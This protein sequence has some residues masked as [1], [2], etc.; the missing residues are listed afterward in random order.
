MWSYVLA[1]EWHIP[2]RQ[3][4]NNFNKT[5]ELSELYNTTL[6]HA[7]I[8]EIYPGLPDDPTVIF[9]F[10]ASEQPQQQGH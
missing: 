6:F 10:L 7:F 1:K 8:E 3:Y 2:G 9:E 4:Q 5:M